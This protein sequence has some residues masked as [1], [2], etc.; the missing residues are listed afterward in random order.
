MPKKRY[1]TEE[2]IQHLRTAEIKQSK[3]LSQGE[4]ARKVS[5]TKVTLARLRNEYGGLKIDQ[6]RRLKDLEAENN[7]LKKIVADLSI[8][9]SISKEV[10]KGNF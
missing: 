5:V 9:N 1:T 10:A 7:R 3:G 6:A 2:I 4:V 8:D